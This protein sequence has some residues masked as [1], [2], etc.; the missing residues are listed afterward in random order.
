MTL[1]EQNVMQIHIAARKYQLSILV[2]RCVE[3]LDN[4]L[5]ASNACSILDHC[6]LF[7]EN[8]LSKKCLDII[9]RNTAEALASDGFMNISSRTLGVILDNAHLAMKEIKIF[10]KAFE[11]ASKKNDGS[12]NARTALG[13]NLFKIRFPAMKMK[14]FTEIVCAKDVLTENEQLQ[15]FKYLASPKSGKPKSFC[16]DA[17]KVKQY[18]SANLPMDTSQQISSQ[19]NGCNL[20]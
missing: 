7:G 11:W 1:N 6:Q 4:E 16:C 5:T 10:E 9:E 20:M 8:D 13:N 17:R 18:Q 15:I 2:N 19:S 14:E 12:V 3:F